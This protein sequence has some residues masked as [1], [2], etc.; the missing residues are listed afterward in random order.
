KLHFSRF[1]QEPRGRDG[2]KSS[3]SRMWHLAWIPAFAGMTIVVWM[4]FAFPDRHPGE[5]RGPRG[6]VTQRSQQAPQGGRDVLRVERCDRAPSFPLVLEADEGQRAGLE[7]AARQLVDER[8]VAAVRD[9]DLAGTGLEH[10]L[11]QL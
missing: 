3:T 10:G 2:C 7:A 6:R 1:V 11:D 4:P 9:P 8:V 5:G